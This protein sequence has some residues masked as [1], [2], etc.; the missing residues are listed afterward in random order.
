VTACS[1]RV[2][3]TMAGG[4]QAR[5]RRRISRPA[6]T[7]AAMTTVVVGSGTATVTS[8]CPVACVKVRIWLLASVPVV[9][10]PVPSL[11]NDAFA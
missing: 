9:Q 11:V 4:S 10:M 1:P 2:G 7:E 8:S 6:A 3:I 5:F